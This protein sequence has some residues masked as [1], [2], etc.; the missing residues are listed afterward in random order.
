MIPEFVNFLNIAGKVL[1][2]E[3]LFLRNAI[4]A[5][6]AVYP[7]SN[8]LNHCGLLRFNN[9]WYYQFAIARGL[10]GAY[11]F[12]V[13]VER[14]KDRFDLTLAMPRNGTP[15]FAAL[16]MKRWMSVGGEGKELKGILGDLSK[17]DKKA[18]GK[19]S[20]GLMII[21]SANE[22]TAQIKDSKNWL[23]NEIRKALFPVVS[24]APYLFP[25][26]NNQG[27][28][29]YFWIAGYEVF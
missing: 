25:T 5:N 12:V 7:P 27:T 24:T 17:L 4:S 16:E 14:G 10:F 19:A 26:Y 20:H 2:K 23:E 21:F 28:P 8:P 9:E 6:P 3:D 18:K 1:E 22:T 29:V 13:E 15:L 11:P